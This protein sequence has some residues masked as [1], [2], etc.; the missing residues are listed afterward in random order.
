MLCCVIAGALFAAVF[1][2]LARLPLVGRYFRRRRDALARASEWR[3]F[4]D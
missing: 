3:L 4:D 1:H 2:E